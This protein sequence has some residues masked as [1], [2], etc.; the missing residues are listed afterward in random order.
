MKLDEFIVPQSEAYQLIAC[1]DRALPGAYA[2]AWDQLCA[3]YDN[4]RRQVDNIINNLTSME[5]IRDQ[6]DHYFR[7][8]TIIN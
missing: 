4:P 8:Y 5:A 7:M 3:R 1:Y 2:D 6:R